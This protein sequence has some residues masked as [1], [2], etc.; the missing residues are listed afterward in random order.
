MKNSYWRQKGKYQD[1]VD[2]ADK[3]MPNW[4]YTE[5]NYMNLF[6]D[7]SKLY[8]DCYNNGGWNIYDCYMDRVA[9]V[10]KYIRLDIRKFMKN[11]E[12]REEKTD[13]VFA[14]LLD[15]D[16][17]YKQYKAY[18]NG[19]DFVSYTQK[20]SWSVITFGSKEERKDW[21]HGRIK[22]CKSKY[23]R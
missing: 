6:I 14:F 1:F 23:V 10:K 12:Y 13:E 16:L 7:I 11:E 5:N 18:F 3:L 20:E 15:K 4:G 19:R 21:V 2:E 8:Y 9:N 22:N 17:S